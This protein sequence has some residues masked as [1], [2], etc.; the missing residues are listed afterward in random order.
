MLKR[1]ER[2]DLYKSQ[3]GREKIMEWY[4]SVV[5]KIDAPVRSVWAGTRFGR[6]HLLT[7]GRPDAEPLILLPGAA[8]SAPLFR[9]AIVH[10]FTVTSACLRL[11]S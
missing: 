5:A 4:D 8:G 10:L 1:V 7:A 3:E 6:T 11:M 9:R 2:L